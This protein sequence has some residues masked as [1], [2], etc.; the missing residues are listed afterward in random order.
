[1]LP[2]FGETHIFFVGERFFYPL[3]VPVFWEKSDKY[4]IKVSCGG[5]PI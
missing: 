5:V 2:C 1:L 4:S 3:S